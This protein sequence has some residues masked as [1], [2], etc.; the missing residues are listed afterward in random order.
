MKIHTLP[1]LLSFLSP[2]TANADLVAHWSLEEGLGTTATD[3]TANNRNGTLTSGVTWNT[4]DLPPV[5]TGSIAAASFDGL[6]GQIDITGYKGISGT[7]DRS[8]SAWIKTETDD[9]IQDMAIVSWGSNLSTQKWTFRVNSGNGEQGTIRIE[10]NGGFFVGNTVVTDAQW[11]HVVVTWADDGTPNIV[12]A[13]LYV[14]G[15]LDAELG[16][17]ESPPSA[18]QSVAINTA[19]GADV[20]IGENFVVDR[21]WQGFIDEV[22][23]Y[24]EALDAEEIAN[25]FSGTQIL[26]GFVANEEAV[27]SGAPVELSWTADSANDTL[28]IDNG[29]GDVSGSNMITVNPT[30]TTTYTL[31]GT[32]GGETQE[33]EITVLV[34]EDPLIRLFDTL[35]ADMILSGQSIEL[36]F[37][38]FGEASLSINGTDVSGE[39]SLVVS[40]TE[41]TTYVLTATNPFGSVTSEV[42]VLVLDESAPN[43]SWSAADLVDGSLARWDPAINTTGNNGIAFVNATGGEV[44]SGSSNFTGVNAWVNSPGYNLNG[45]P[46]DSWQDGL[47]NAVTQQDVSWEMV[48]RPGDFTGTHTLFNTGGSGSGTAFT[49]TGSTLNFILQAVANDAQRVI[50]P[51]DLATL[52]EATDF[53]H[54]VATADVGAT[55][56]GTAALYVNGVLVNGPSSSTGIINDWDGSDLAEL[57]K[58]ANIP[59]N[60]AFPFEAFTGDIATLS[61][62]ENRI[63]DAGQITAKYEEIAGVGGELVITDISFDRGSGEISITFDSVSGRTYA[64]ETEIDLSEEQWFEVEDSILAD[65]S[66]TVFTLNESSLPDVGSLKRFFRIRPGVQ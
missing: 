7:G 58:G 34:D 26:S 17:L 38:V 20:R 41:T 51:I 59:T 63:L 61:Y 19:S 24:D 23:I 48:F 22:R 50:L 25:L 42:T 16:N 33:K 12:D 30:T 32:R 5:P 36:S 66:Q 18:S 57:G 9:V 4:T 21:N 11:H 37:D 40:P 3:S 46:G 10:A 62:Y 44:Q 35:Q 39:M 31:T 47:G 45:N 60:A 1:I 28:M 27:A 13:K 8:I 14:D 64:L 52:G 65:D 2:L 54:V 49:L 15:V 6:N 43:L 53:F 56:V 29:V 55:G